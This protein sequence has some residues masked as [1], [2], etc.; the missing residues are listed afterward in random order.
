MK[1]EDFQTPCWKR[2]SKLLDERIDELRKLN[3][4][5]SFGPEETAAVRG[6]I[7]ELKKILDLAESASSGPAVNP[8]ELVGVDH[9]H[10]Q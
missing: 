4:S 5:M 2:L 6:G 1:T 3:D 8:D 9:Y 7:R 10:G